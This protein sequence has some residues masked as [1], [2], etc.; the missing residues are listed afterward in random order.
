MTNKIVLDLETQ[1]EFSEVGGRNK[2]HLLKVSVAGIYSFADD[3]YRIFEERELHKLG[4]LLAAADQVIGFNILQFDYAVLAPYVNF[5]LEKIPSLD[6]LVEL[7]K[8]LGHRISLEAVAQATLGTGKSGSGME[9][10]R[11][12][13]AGQLEDLKKYCLDDVKL[14]KEVYEYG[15]KYGKLLYQ[16][17]F[18]TREIPV[19]FPEPQIRQ[20]VVKQTSLF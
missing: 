9:A 3:Q 11:L 15:Q 4:E 8:I 2:H 20:N 16:D 7:E 12:W 18:E 14:T 17:F 6:I 5:S 10:L 1:R 13:K 19:S